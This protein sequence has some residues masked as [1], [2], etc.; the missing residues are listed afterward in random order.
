VRFLFAVTVSLVGSW[1]I[2]CDCAPFPEPKKALEKATAVC[3]AEVT[4]VEE[5]GD[6]RTVTLK[7]EKWWKGG[8]AAEL[9]VSTHKNGAT[10][11]YAFKQGGKYLIYTGA[12]DKNK[13]LR[14]SLCSRTRTEKQAEMDGDFKE[15]GEGKAPKK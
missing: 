13:T 5:D 3:L 10:C 4:K 15:L 9:K 8:E 2:A 14:V 1:L 12:E 11:G 6:H 7:V